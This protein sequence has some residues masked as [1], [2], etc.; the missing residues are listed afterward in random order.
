MTTLL[1]SDICVL[2]LTC[3]VHCIVTILA[4]RM[5]ALYAVTQTTATQETAETCLQ[6]LITNAGYIFSLFGSYLN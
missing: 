2:T 5:L 1:A 3:A 6:I 4:T